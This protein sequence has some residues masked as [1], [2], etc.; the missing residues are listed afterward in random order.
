MTV[1]EVLMEM[2]PRFDPQGPSVIIVDG[3]CA[4]S[5]TCG[6]F[7]DSW[8]ELCAKKVAAVKDNVVY[9]D[10]FT[11]QKRED[12]VPLSLLYFL[13]KGEFENDEFKI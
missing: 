4:L 10:I 13:F 3:N 8:E 1:G 12:F 5:G 2:K 9:I 7:L 11:N 6:Y